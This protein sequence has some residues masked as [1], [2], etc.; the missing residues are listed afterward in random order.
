MELCNRAR[1][2]DRN[3][4]PLIKHTETCDMA[5][6][7]RGVRSVLACGSLPLSCELLLPAAGSCPRGL[8]SPPRE[9]AAPEKSR[10]PFQ[11]VCLCEKDF[12]ERFMLAV[13]F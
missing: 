2:T 13:T 3:E 9:L 6:G 12:L 11:G 7:P 5:A 8:I 4:G 1:E 10:L